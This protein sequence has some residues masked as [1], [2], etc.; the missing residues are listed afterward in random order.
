MSKK[1]DLAMIIIRSLNGGF[2]L[3]VALEREVEGDLML[4]DMGQVGLIVSSDCFIL[5][6]IVI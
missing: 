6:S 5:L 2:I 3:D 4:G 1:T